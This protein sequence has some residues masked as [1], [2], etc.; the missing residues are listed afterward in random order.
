MPFPLFIWGG[1]AIVT[2]LAGGANTAAACGRIGAAENRYRQRRGRYDEA[3]RHFEQRHREAA[4][5]FEDL[6]KTRLNAVVTLGKAVD[7]LKKARVKK[8]DLF[9]KF[10]ITPEQ[11]VAWR[12]ASV[13]ALDILGGVA[14]SALSGVATSAAVYGLVGTLGAAS[15][16]TAIGALSGAA[17]SNATL[18]WLGGGTLAT[19]GFGVAGGT[20]V[21]GGLVVGPAILVASFFAHA[22]AGKIENQVERH[23]SEMDVDEAEKGKFLAALDAILARVRELKESTVRLMEELEHLLVVS[24]PEYDQEAYLVAKTAVAL[25]LLL[26]VAILDKDGNPL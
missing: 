13:H 8:R 6:G 25:G 23:V 26:E 16:G 11:L 18:A 2:A 24:N 19:G 21:L 10:S 5:H 7:F 20:A 14:S 17:A 9:E 22:K 4:S 15:T 1:I 3:M 12:T